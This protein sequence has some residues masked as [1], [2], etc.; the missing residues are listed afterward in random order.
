MNDAI[1]SRE[2]RGMGSVVDFP[3]WSK[4]LDGMT[5]VMSKRLLKNAHL[6]FQSFEDC[7][8]FSGIPLQVQRF[9]LFQFARFSAFALFVCVSLPFLRFHA[10]SE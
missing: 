4:I 7:M 6:S 10:L 9:K 2:V 3:V 5:F 8:P 1:D